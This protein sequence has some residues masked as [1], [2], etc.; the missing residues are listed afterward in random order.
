MDDLVQDCSNSIV[1]ALELLQSCT[2]S[3]ISLCA[4]MATTLEALNNTLKW[5]HQ[6]LSRIYKYMGYLNMN[7][8]VI[9]RG[10][11]TNHT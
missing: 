2:K 8:N 11:I 3:L 10:M 9:T 6:N 1:N 7:E 5:K 4:N